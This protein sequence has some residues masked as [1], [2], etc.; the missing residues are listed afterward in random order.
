MPAA[1]AAS[2][3][4]WMLAWENRRLA[5]LQPAKELAF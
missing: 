3:F 5:L 2:T 1:S 4:S